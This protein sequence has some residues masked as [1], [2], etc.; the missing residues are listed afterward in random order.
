MYMSALF[1]CMRVYCVCLCAHMCVHVVTLEIRRRSLL[2]D[3]SYRQ[4]WVTMWVLGI[5]SV[6]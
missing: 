6:S 5:N 3:W 2:W 1:V 4:L